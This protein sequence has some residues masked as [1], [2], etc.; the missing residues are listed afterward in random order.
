MVI[1][2][3]QCNLEFSQNHNRITPHFCDH[4]CDAVYKMRFERLEIGI[5]FK[6][7][8]FSTQPKTNISLY[9]EPS[10]KLLS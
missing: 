4:M 2:V 3:V 5:F 10:F 6:F 8:A 1:C 9:F 7:W